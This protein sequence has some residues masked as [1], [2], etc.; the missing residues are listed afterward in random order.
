MKTLPT[1]LKAQGGALLI[2]AMIA[3]LIF[4]FGVLAIVGMQATS[5]RQTTDAKYRLDASFM[6]NQILGEMWV[7]KSALST[8]VVNRAALPGLPNGFKTV[9]VAGDVVTVTIFWHLP[10]ETVDHVYTTITQIKS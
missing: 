2:E 1:K 4:S 6:A 5:L 7:K 3:I 9:A 10:G 8:F